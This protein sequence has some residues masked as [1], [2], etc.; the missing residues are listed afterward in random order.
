MSLVYVLPGIYKSCH[1]GVYIYIGMYR[2]CIVNVSIY[3]LYNTHI[4]IHD[5]TCVSMSA[6]S[7]YYS[8]FPHGQTNAFSFRFQDDMVPILDSSMK[9]EDGCKT[10]T[11]YIYIFI[12][13]LK[14]I[15]CG[16]FKDKPIFSDD[17]FEMSIFYLL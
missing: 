10:E 3:S 1:V 7:K 16:I 12:V 14:S 9:L 15:K 17:C 13:I 5:H 11:W 8:F 2:S 6:I 4:Y